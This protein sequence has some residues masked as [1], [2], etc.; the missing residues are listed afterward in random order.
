MLNTHLKAK[1]P[2]K[3]IFFH[4]AHLN[5]VTQNLATYLINY[6]MYFNF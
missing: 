6:E 3:I 5:L 1:A 4:L 2:W